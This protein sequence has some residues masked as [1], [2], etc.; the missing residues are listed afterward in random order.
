MSAFYLKNN[1]CFENVLIYTLY[2]ISFLSDNI[3]GLRKYTISQNPPHSN[4]LRYSHRIVLLFG[5]RGQSRTL[6]LRILIE[7]Y[8]RPSEVALALFNTDLYCLP[9]VWGGTREK[10]E[11][12]GEKWRDVEKTKRAVVESRRDAYRISRDGNSSMREVVTYA[13]KCA[14]FYSFN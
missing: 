3:P 8:C 1:S 10:V 14:W 12:H 7:I 5:N 9:R 11:V 2:Y 4:F 6:Q 13:M